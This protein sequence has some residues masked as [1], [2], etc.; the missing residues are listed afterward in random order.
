MVLVHRASIWLPI[1]AGLTYGHLSLSA[2]DVFLPNGGFMLLHNAELDHFLTVT[3]SILENVWLLVSFLQTSASTPSTRTT[4][5]CDAEHN[6]KHIALFLLSITLILSYSFI[7]CAVCLCFLG[8]ARK[9]LLPTQVKSMRFTACDSK[10]GG[11]SVCVYICTGRKTTL[12]TS[13]RWSA[14]NRPP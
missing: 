11:G 7:S 12:H 8:D 6:V 10:P 3:W 4:P 5:Y 14:L 2:L 9:S 13:D 1:R